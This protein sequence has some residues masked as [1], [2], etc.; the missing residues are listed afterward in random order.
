MCMH[1]H[2][3]MHMESD[4]VKGQSFARARY[5]TSFV[6]I[7]HANTTRQLILTS[8]LGQDSAGRTRRNVSEP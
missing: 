8:F 6:I 1:H 7:R 2:R 4:E 5:C 3:I